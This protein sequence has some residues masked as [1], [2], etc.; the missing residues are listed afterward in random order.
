MLS[1]DVCRLYWH[2]LSPCRK[3]FFFCCLSLKS[4]HVF[5]A[6]SSFTSL[7]LP[8][9]TTCPITYYFLYAGIISCYL[10]SSYKLLSGLHEHPC[11]LNK[12]GTTVISHNRRY[13][14]H[15]LEDFHEMD[16]VHLECSSVMLTLIL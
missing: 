5:K 11:S 14:S 6:A 1:V 16:T 4:A 10:E 3:S 13:S 15:F 7:Q 8:Q 2:L 9:S 12:G